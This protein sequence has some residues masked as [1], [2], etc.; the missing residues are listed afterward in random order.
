MKPE[1][2]KSI[3]E[4]LS[5]N[6]PLSYV[7]GTRAL[8]S[9]ITESSGGISLQSS[10]GRSVSLYLGPA[11]RYFGDPKDPLERGRGR[12]AVIINRDLITSAAREAE[13][14]WNFAPFDIGEVLYHWNEGSL[15]RDYLRGY[16]PQRLRAALKPLDDLAADFAL[17]LDECYEDPWNYFRPGQRPRPSLELDELTSA[18]HKACTDRWFGRVRP[19]SGALT[20]EVRSPLSVVVPDSA[21]LFIAILDDSFTRNAVDYAYLSQRFQSRFIIIPTPATI[22][23]PDLPS[24][25][26]ES[27]TTALV[28]DYLRR[29]FSASE[30]TLF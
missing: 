13:E 28:I 29:Q 21:I 5:R 20:F 18:V 9:W 25:L 6:T 10:T 8:S 26:I 22:H 17:V 24:V 1:E 2:R 7:A 3:I 12:V 15:P 11:R 19:F 27:E 14:D 30:T 4:F 23:H 16:T